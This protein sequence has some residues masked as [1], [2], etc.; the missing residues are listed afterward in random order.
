[1]NEETAARAM[2]VDDHDW[3]L[4]DAKI[5]APTWAETRWQARAVTVT[6]CDGPSK[7]A[8]RP[9]ARRRRSYVRFACRG[10]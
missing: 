8:P 2:C 7:G 6:A 5:R 9:R 4:E 3:Q 1:M 10:G